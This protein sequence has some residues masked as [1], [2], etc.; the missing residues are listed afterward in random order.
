MSK[1]KQW[2]DVPVPQSIIIYLIDIV[3]FAQIKSGENKI[4]SIYL[5]CLK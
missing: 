5:T 1:T 2:H 3:D 4:K